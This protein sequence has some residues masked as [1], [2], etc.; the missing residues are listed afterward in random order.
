[1]ILEINGDIGNI[2]HVLIVA[3]HSQD[4]SVMH[5]IIHKCVLL[6]NFALVGILLPPH[7]ALEPIVTKLDCEHLKFASQAHTVKLL[8]SHSQPLAQRANTARTISP[9][10]RYSAPPGRSALSM[11]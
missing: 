6:V 3:M 11:G 8:D 9:L 5:K 7:A 1:M 2:V 10:R 4:G